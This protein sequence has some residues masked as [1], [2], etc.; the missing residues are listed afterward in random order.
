M[1]LTGDMDMTDA[2]NPH[3]D[4]P[5]GTASPLRRVISLQKYKLA[6]PEFGDMEER[7]ALADGGEILGVLLNDPESVDGEVVLSK[8]FMLSGELAK[9][10]ILSD[11]IGLLQREYDRI[12]GEFYDS[13]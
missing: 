4:N 2:T 11:W 6:A 7:R 9:L 10:D 13:E 5:S 1:T 12:H 8:T 3:D